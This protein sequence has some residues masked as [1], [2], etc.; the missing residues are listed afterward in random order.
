MQ[1]LTKLFFISV[2]GIGVTAVVACSSSTSD[3]SGC[4]ADPFSCAAGQTCAVKDT[5][6]AF[7]CLASGASA[8]GASCQN[9][10]GTTTCGDD[11]VCFQQVASGG[12]CTAYC[13]PTNTAHGCAV[14]ETCRGAALAGTSNIFYVCVTTV[15]DAGTPAADSSVA[16]ASD[17]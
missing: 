6:G 12:A 16:D 17:Q 7:A 3:S 8:K 4:A 2:V 5:T 13:D 10:P 1:S 9:T 15:A 14:T 11:L